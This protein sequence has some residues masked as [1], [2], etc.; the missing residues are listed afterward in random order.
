MGETTPPRPGSHEF[1][2]EKDALRKLKAESKKAT[3]PKEAR[4]IF[5]NQGQNITGQVDKKGT[6]L[7]PNSAK[8]APG[9]GR[10][11]ASR[12]PRAAPI[13]SHW[14]AGLGVGGPEAN[15]GSPSEAASSG[16][17]KALGGAPK[18]SSR[19]YHYK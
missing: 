11:T 4:R 14:T 10:S 19:G 3:E 7:S 18:S 17:N 12:R 15:L 13:T 1:D 6:P 8:A 9:P 2:A 5:G 16:T